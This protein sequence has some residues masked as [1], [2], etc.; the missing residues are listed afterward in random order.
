[1]RK[2]YHGT[3]NLQH[4]CSGEATC[5]AGVFR[6]PKRL[7]VTSWKSGSLQSSIVVKC[8]EV[9]D[10]L[11]ESQSPLSY[12]DIVAKTGFSK[13]S[14]H[15]ILTILMTENL[16]QFDEATRSYSLGPKLVDWARAAWQKTD[17]QQIKDSTLMA[18]R[19]MTNLNV[20]V[21][22]RTND[23]VMFIRTFDTAAVR[24]APRIGQQ[25]ALHCTAAGKVLLAFQNPQ[26]AALPEG[27]ELERYTEKTIVT[28][29]AFQDEL[30]SVV[31]AGYALCDREEFLQVVGMAAPILDYRSNAVAALSL[32]APAKLADIEA[33]QKHSGALVD[34]ANELSKKFGAMSADPSG[35]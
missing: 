22:I 1:M 15:R 21:S 27:Y 35:H 17:L 18:L 2:A 16:L 5:R 23:A 6:L 30:E 4:L 31:A 9:L 13:S 28:E 10:V 24:Y 14:A 7:N 32:W 33:L 29:R 19:D 12:S 8:V 11:S 20:C 34:A 25:S 3:N 26:P